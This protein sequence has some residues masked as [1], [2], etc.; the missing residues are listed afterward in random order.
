MMLILGVVFH[1]V[2]AVALSLPD[3]AVVMILS[4]LLFLDDNLIL[5]RM[6]LPGS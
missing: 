4:Y 1:V 6:G 2:I 3:F 5:S